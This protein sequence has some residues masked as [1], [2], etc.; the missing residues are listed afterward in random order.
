MSWWRCQTRERISRHPDVTVCCCV[1]APLKN[2]VRLMVEMDSIRA[3]NEEASEYDQQVRDYRSHGHDVLFGLVFDY[4]KPHETLLDIGI[5]TGLA[6]WPFAK[7]GLRI[8]GLDGSIKM[9]EVCESKAFTEEL[10]HFDLRTTP[11]PYSDHS[12]DHAICCG[13]LHFFGELALIIAEVSRVVKPAGI[14]AFTIAG[15]TPEEQE[16]PRDDS[17]D[18]LMRPT[19]WGVSIYAHSDGYIDKTLQDHGFETLKTQKILAWSGKDDTGDMLFE[20]VVAR[21]SRS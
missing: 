1:H 4:V 18:Y 9:L 7:T 6:S 13:V 19:P 21:S 5:G 11:L 17:S 3:H 20:I 10:K 12:F 15:Q 14:F 8:F 16:A 2:G